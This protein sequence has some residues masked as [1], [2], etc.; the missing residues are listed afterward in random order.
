MS[1]RPTT[2]P[3]KLHLRRTLSKSSDGFIDLLTTSVIDPRRTFAAEAEAV[4][5]SRRCIARDCDE[6]VPCSVHGEPAE[7]RGEWFRR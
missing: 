1:V 5:Q 2:K 3:A 6:L 4:R 7:D